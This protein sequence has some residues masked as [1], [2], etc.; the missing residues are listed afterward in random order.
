[1]ADEPVERRAIAQN[2]EDDRRGKAGIAPIDARAA[3][4]EPVRSIAAALY[5]LENVEGQAAGGSGNRHS[6][7]SL[8]SRL[9]VSILDISG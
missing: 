3:S 1:M 4:G 5:V 2:A 7:R 9:T 8:Q 6:N